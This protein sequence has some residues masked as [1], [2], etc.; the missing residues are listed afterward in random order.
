MIH[1]VRPAGRIRARGRRMHQYRTVVGR[2]LGVTAGRIR[3]L[4]R[5]GESGQ[6]GDRI[7]PGLNQ[8]EQTGGRDIVKRGRL[9][10]NLPPAGPDAIDDAIGIRVQQLAHGPGF[11]TGRRRALCG[12]CHRLTASCTAGRGR[13][14][15]ER[16]ARAPGAD[17]SVP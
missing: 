15:R 14:R 13:D 1:G 3:N 10:E 7:Q 4:L 6:R 2:D 17:D 11:R 16:S 12:G 8:C 5:G 9:L